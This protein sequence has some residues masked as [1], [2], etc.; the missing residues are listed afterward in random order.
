MVCQHVFQL[1]QRIP[2]SKTPYGYCLSF[3]DKQPGR[4][5]KLNNLYATSNLR[6]RSSNNWDLFVQPLTYANNKQ[7][8]RNTHTALYSLV[9]SRHEPRTLLLSATTIA[10]NKK[11]SEISSHAIHNSFNNAY[12]YYAQRQIRTYVNPKPGTCQITVTS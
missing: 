1:H 4:A 12:L 3:T 2:R 8:Q 5:V 10:P 6:H 7:V 9:L 11:T